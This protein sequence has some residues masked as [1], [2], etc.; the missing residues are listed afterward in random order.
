[1]TEPVSRA[2][3][4]A[5]YQAYAARDAAKVAEFLADDVEWTI[6]GPVDVLPFC[7]TRHGK[8]AVLDLIERQVPAVFGIISFVRD[9]TLVD[10]DQVA[11]LSRLAARGKDGRM[12]SYRL[13][14]FLRFRAGKV[15]ENVSLIDSFDAAEQVLGH[16]LDV[17][18]G[19]WREAGDLIAV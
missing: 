18:E 4:E 16:P 5:F 19:E 11:T 12:I 9:A 1:M 13:A 17:H 3:V 14:H 2:R 10:G 7:G 15:V 6:R 8:T